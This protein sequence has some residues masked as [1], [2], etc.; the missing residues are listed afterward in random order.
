MFVF[1]DQ[2]AFSRLC[3]VSGRLHQLRKGLQVAYESQNS[4]KFELCG[5]NHCNVVNILP[6]TLDLTVLNRMS[7]G[8]GRLHYVR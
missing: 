8:F 1:L 5:C 3:D 7:G 2:T 4:L 6:V